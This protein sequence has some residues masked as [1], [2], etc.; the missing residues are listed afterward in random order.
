MLNLI[1]VYPIPKRGGV[2]KVSGIDI[3]TISL[4]LFNETLC[5]FFEGN[6]NQVLQM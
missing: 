6:I 4:Y 1:I 3:D 2:G 5:R